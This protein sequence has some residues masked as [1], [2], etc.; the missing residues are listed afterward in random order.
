[1]TSWGYLRVM[2]TVDDLVDTLA[3]LRVFGATVVDEVV[4]Y[5]HTFCLCYVWGPEASPQRGSGDGDRR[6]MVILRT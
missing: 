6:P 2:F 5:R 3:W 1:M 4:D